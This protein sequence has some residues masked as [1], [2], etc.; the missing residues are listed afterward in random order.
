[1]VLQAPM[2]GRVLLETMT[3]KLQKAWAVLEELVLR[4]PPAVLVAAWLAVALQAQLVALEPRVA[5]RAM[6]EPAAV[7]DLVGRSNALAAPADL[8]APVVPEPHQ[9]VAAAAVRLPDVMATTVP[10]AI[11]V[12]RV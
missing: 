9:V 7:G 10:M 3:T 4:D 1:M 6:A 11:P 12:L 2:V 5:Q 8:A